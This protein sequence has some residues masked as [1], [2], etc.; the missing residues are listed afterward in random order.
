[1]SDST[2][3]QRFALKLASAFEDLERELAP[4]V[5][6]GATVRPGRPR[7]QFAYG[8]V[9]IL[10]GAGL[11]WQQISR[12]LGASRTTVRRVHAN[13]RRTSS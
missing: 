12:E 9:L 2:P 4:G 6:L 8:K 13:L 1:M 10:R 7:A 3:V 5:R 11:S